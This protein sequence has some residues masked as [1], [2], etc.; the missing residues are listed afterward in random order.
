MD[1]FI[2]PQVLLL[3][4]AKVYMASR[5]KERAEE[6]IATLKEETGNEAIFLQLDLSSWDSVR[7]ASDELKLC[8]IL[9]I[10]KPILSI[11]HIERRLR[12]MFF[13][14]T[15]EGKHPVPHLV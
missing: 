3:K 2:R 8:V 5:S 15:G 11:V 6:A 4:N 9:L 14:T 10:S 12:F 1:R 13:S 7:K